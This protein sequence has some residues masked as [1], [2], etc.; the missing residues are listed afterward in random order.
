VPIS[1]EA[2]GVFGG[3]HAGYDWQLP[4]RFVIGFRVAAPLGSVTFRSLAT[5][6]SSRTLSAA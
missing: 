2:D 1:I 3:I 4:N 6:A 5:S